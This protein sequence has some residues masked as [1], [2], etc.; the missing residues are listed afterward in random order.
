MIERHH[1][2][3]L[4][5]EHAHPEG[6]RAVVARVLAVLPGLPGV[7]EVSAGEPADGDAERSW[8]LFV[9]VRFAS[10]ADVDAYRA[11]PAHR[12]FVDG[13]LSPRV[14]VKKVWNFTARSVGGSSPRS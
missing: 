5:S 11:D 14:E 10:L 2:F 3:K 7:I 6:R 4:K 12:E 9:T 8:D 13:F 1:Y